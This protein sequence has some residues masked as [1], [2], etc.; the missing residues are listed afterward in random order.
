MKA[1]VE[2]HP[3]ISFVVIAFGWT[4]P[5]AA[6]IEVSL[7][8]P[9]L[10]LFGPCV[11]AVVVL[12]V[13]RGRAGLA[14]L[15]RKFRL[16]KALAPW[17]IVAALLPIVLLGPLWILHVWWWGRI[18]FELAE[19]SL[20]S[21]V[22]AVLIVGEEVGWRGFLLPL[23]LRRYAPLTSSLIVGLVWAVWHLPNFLLPNYPHR[24]LPFSAFVLMTVSYSVLF[25]W[26]YLKTAGSLLVAVIFHAALNLFSLGGVEPARQYWLKAV[27]YAAA[28][29]F[30]Y[31]VMRRYF[32][33]RNASVTAV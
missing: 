22:L 27:V 19:L 24:G 9:L 17:C 28:A 29:L 12:A 10:A 3:F 18:G 5:L 4:W 26:L 32:V 1:I 21:L 23:L 2:K 14:E 15:G 6:L 13:C 8:F 7:I 16:S 11:A 20:L 31:A 33:R 30:V 25:T